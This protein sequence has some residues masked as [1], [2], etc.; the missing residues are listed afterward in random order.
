[1]SHPPFIFVL[2]WKQWLGQEA[3][4]WFQCWKNSTF[5]CLTGLITL[6][7][8]MWEWMDL[9]LRKNHLLRCW[10]WLSLPNWFGAL[11]LSLLLKLASRKLELVFLP[12]FLCISINLSYGHA[13]NT[14][15]MEYS[16]YLELLD[17]LQKWICRTVGPS[18]A[19]SLEPLVHRR[20]A[21]K[22]S[23]FYMYYFGRC[24]SELAELVPFPYSRG[25]STRYSDRLHDISVTISRCYKDVMSTVL[26]LHS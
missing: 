26:S 2:S 21:T 7:L 6:V 17:K 4:C 12:R 16:Y 9:F 13:W 25:R 10:D 1:M 3:D 11:T 15:V 5:F 18:L 23:L 24:S 22:L 14:F 19:A 20:N 8:L